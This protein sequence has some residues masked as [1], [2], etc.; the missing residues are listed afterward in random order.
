MWIKWKVTL[1]SS[2]HRVINLGSIDQVSREKF[3][4]ELGGK[5][6]HSK[7]IS[8]NMSQKSWTASLEKRSRWR[9]GWH[10]L[11]RYMDSDNL[12]G[13]C[14]NADKLDYPRMSVW[15]VW[16]M[17][18]GLYFHDSRIHM[19]D[20]LKNCPVLYSCHLLYCSVPTALSCFPFQ[21]FIKFPFEKFVLSLLPPFLSSTVFQIIMIHYGEKH[22]TFPL[23]FLMLKRCI[24]WHQCHCLR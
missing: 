7:Y 12:E 3:K 5:L 16:T 24:F 1:F 20:F 9:F 13:Y 10:R 15:L 23:F 18:V 11:D 4:R 2:K 8:T 19:A 21:M 6:W 14:P 22:L 17:A